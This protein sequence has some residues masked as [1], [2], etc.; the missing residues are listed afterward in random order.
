MMTGGKSPFQ[1]DSDYL[2]MIAARGADWDRKL[3]PDVNV[4]EQDRQ[5]SEDLLLKLVC[6]EPSDRIGARDYSELKQ[7]EY[8][9][10]PNGV[11]W[12]NMLSFSV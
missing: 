5:I 3:P 11:N 2:T 1:K 6:V 7:H 12:D 9:T 10:F 8:F 4:P